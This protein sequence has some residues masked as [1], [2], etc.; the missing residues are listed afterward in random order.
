MLLGFLSGLKKAKIKVVIEGISCTSLSSFDFLMSTFFLFK[1]RTV[2]LLGSLVKG[3][4]TY[5]FGLL[6]VGTMNE[7]VFPGKKAKKQ[8]TSVKPSVKYLDAP[9]NRLSE[10]LCMRFIVLQ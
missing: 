10:E 8:Q 1:N 2:E 6:T 5:P 3:D 7:S 4:A 9:C